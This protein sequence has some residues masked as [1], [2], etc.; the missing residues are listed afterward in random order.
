[1]GDIAKEFN[2]VDF[3]GMLI[4]GFLVTML[5]SYEFGGWAALDLCFGTDVGAL[6]KIIIFT[7][8]GYVVGMLFHEVGDVLE[9]MLW[10][11][12]IVNPRTY[13]AYNTKLIDRYGGIIN[14][15]VPSP[16]DNSTFMRILFCIISL[17]STVPFALVCCFAFQS[18]PCVWILFCVFYSVVAI[19]NSLIQLGIE[20]NVFASNVQCE[21]NVEPT[22][23]NT[24]TASSDP[25]GEKT[26]EIEEAI[27]ATDPTKNKNLIPTIISICNNDAMLMN[28]AVLMA[29]SNENVRKETI[30][31][32]NLFDGFRTMARNGFLV[33]AFLRIYA[34]QT[35]GNLSV[36]LSKIE[37]NCVYSAIVHIGLIILLVR[38][39]HY[40]YLK[41]KYCYEDVLKAHVRN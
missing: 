12:Y 21:K 28:M 29:G 11:N 38:Y 14:D 13:A 19:I 15:K 33:G 23:T 5:F 16:K 7:I 25:T 18:L 17:G 37:G 1:M 10:K 31:K 39:W 27:D 35:T 36:I 22:C 40:S 32:R 41:Y 24:N 4:P 30:R 8:S 26:P 34:G 9:K 6:T 3:I 2:M 20:P